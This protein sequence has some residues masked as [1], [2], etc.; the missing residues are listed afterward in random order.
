MT[1]LNVSGGPSECSLKD[2]GRPNTQ[3]SANTIAACL[4]KELHV[5]ATHE[6]LDFRGRFHQ[7]KH[8]TH[9]PLLGTCNGNQTMEL[10]TMHTKVSAIPRSNCSLKAPLL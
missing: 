9:G 2:I 1:V 3:H 10:V 6:R 4:P 7:E 5:P 8:L